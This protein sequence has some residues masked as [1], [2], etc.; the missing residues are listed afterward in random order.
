LDAAPAF[1]HEP[2]T[3]ARWNARR[4]EREWHPHLAGVGEGSLIGAQ[5]AL[6]MTSYELKAV[7]RDGTLLWHITLIDQDRTLCGKVLREHVKTRPITAIDSIAPARRCG[8]CLS[9]YRAMHEPT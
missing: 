6:G 3:V 4:E 5:E 9:A 8:M 7:D 1:F 2:G